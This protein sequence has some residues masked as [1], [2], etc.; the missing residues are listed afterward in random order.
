[1]FKRSREFDGSSGTNPAS[2]RSSPWHAVSIATGNWCCGAA[3][4]SCGIRYLSA[5]A[6]RLPLAQ[7]DAPESCSCLYR[8][9]CDR[10]DQP[11]RRDEIVGL[12]RKGYVAQERRLDR[13]RR[14][15]DNPSPTR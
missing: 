11:R 6:P 8:H 15:D 1:M 10:R 2:H 14:E 5:Y 3:R 4:A 7:C 13:G 12:R 9:H